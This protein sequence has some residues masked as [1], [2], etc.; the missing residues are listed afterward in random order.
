MNVLVTGGGG[1]LGRHI[2]ERL[3]AR[4]DRVSVLGRNAYPELQ[5]LGATC[6]QGDVADRA[7]VAAA[8]EGAEVVFHVAARVGLEGNFEAF[9]R[10]N[11]DGTDH[12]I[13]GCKAAGTRRLVFTSSP[14][15]VFDGTD[16]EGI[17]ESHPYPERYLAHYPST[18][19]EAERRI[20]AANGQGG[21]TTVSLRPHLIFGPRDTSLLPRLIDRARKGQLRQIGDGKNRVD[22]V[23]VDNAAEAHLLAADAAAAAGKAYFISQGE[24]VLLW[25]WLRE[26]LARLGLPGIRG[27]V[28]TALAYAFGAIAETAH[29]ALGRAGEPRLNRFLVSELSHSHYFSIEN[30]RR[31]LGYRPAVSL[32]DGTNR[33]VAWWHDQQAVTTRSRRR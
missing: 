22:L 18:K 26:L 15:V 5:K 25:E 7:K 28:P 21:L 32:A 14:S 4:G 2:V 16:Q 9:W 31:D 23:Y 12:V 6:I 27:R 17:D 13:L 8:C 20:L 24:P 19:A 10:A 1:F 29:T 11:V 33:L 30:A 3:L